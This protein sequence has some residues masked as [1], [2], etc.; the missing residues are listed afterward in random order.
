MIDLSLLGRQK[1]EEEQYGEMRMQRRNLKTTN[2]D[3]THSIIKSHPTLDSV[4]LNSGIQRG[5]D[6]TKPETIDLDNI[7]L[8]LT[9]NY[10]SYIHL[11]KYLL[12]HL[13]SLST[14][15]SLIF[16]TSGLALVPITRCGNYCASK[17]AL[18]HLIIVMREQMK[19]GPGNVKVVEIYPP[20][21]QTELHDEKHQPDIKNGSSFGM[22]LDEF[23]ETAWKGLTEGKDD[24]PVGTSERA[25]EAFEVKR[26]EIFGH[27]V[28]SMRGPPV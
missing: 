13:Q 5:L 14:P 11:A 9:T 27:M 19:N 21:V 6:F 26:R 25:Y 23:T 4:F 24:I 16:T 1:D 22:P 20:A 17:A 10:I 18:H 15:T 3:K 8:E 2:T 7:S 12:P 28:K